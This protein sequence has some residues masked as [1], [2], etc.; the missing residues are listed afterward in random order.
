[1]TILKI[2]FDAGHGLGTYGKEI[3]SYMGSFDLKKEWEL[4][5]RITRYA[6]QL[7]TEYENVEVL[8]LDDI[9][10]K[11]DV[12]LSER[13]S[14]ANKWGADILISNHHNAGIGGKIGGGTVVFR[15]P[16]STKF[17]KTMQKSLYN[18]LVEETSLKG[19]RYYPTPE[20]NFHMLRESNMPAV[21]IEHGF[22]DS[23]T[24]LPIILT[25]EFAKQS[26][27]GL[28]NWL[29][30]Q[31]N[32][33]KK[34]QEEI[35]IDNKKELFRVQTGAFGVKSN[36]EKLIKT[37]KNKGYDALLVQDNKLYKVQVGAYSNRENAEN[38]STKLAKD[39]FD[40]FITTKQGNI[41]TI[42][43]SDTPVV[44]IKSE[45]VVKNDIEESKEFVGDRAKELQEK[46]IKSGYPL[47]KYGADGVYGQ[48]TH[49]ALIKFQR[50]NGLTVDGLA[51]NATFA[52]LDE[53]IKS[54]TSQT[55]KSNVLIKELQIALNK[56]YKSN[57]I[58]DGIYGENTE[59]ALSKIVLKKGA[60]ND[61]VKILQKKLTSLGFSA[62]RADGIFGI[63]TG[64]AVRS[65]QIKQKISADGIVGK[66]TW[67]KLF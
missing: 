3:P 40:N 29:V 32:L 53:I 45:T 1:M 65:F 63:K 10:G 66:Q 12:P 17:T 36:A 56:N 13:T 15:Y 16:N 61:L 38:M 18:S 8:R 19:N 35:V 24:D 37:I 62:G 25:D 11:R 5:E 43:R 34:P 27:K 41:I 46:L 50:E 6:E 47:P 51:G 42:S 26:A 44:E 58:V 33:I 4:N 39:G 9:T 21:L 22:M 54:K 67:S 7:L 48:E 60:K 64:N 2:A 52:K 31:Y 30:N 23:K 49:D 55:T 14:K 20:A 59:S 57:L 28:V